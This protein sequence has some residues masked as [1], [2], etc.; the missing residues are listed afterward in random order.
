MIEALQNAPAF[1]GH[2]RY[3]VAFEKLD[4]K[5]QI[6][7]V[8]DV[9][10]RQ[11]LLRDKT[12]GRSTKKARAEVTYQAFKNLH[13]QGFSIKSVLNFSQRH[14]QALVNQWMEG[15]LAAA[16]L[17]T[18]FSILRWFTAAIGKN[19][20]LKEPS[21]Y[22][23]PAD[24]IKRVYVAVKDKSWSAIDLSF[25]E[26]IKQI[27]DKDPWVSM[28]LELMDAFGLRIQEATLLQP[29]AADGGSVLRVE[30]G[31]KGGRSRLVQI[32]SAKQRDV[33]NRAKSIAHLSETRN[34][35]PS[36]KILAQALARA[37][38]ICGLFG[39]TKNGMEITPH[40]LRA[41][42]AND[43]YEQ[44]SGMPST[45]RGTPEKFDPEKD[46]LARETVSRELGHSRLSITGAY[47]GARVRGRPKA[48]P[49]ND[50]DDTA[51][52]C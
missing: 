50:G 31:T 29:A 15:G 52:I 46:R 5:R 13:E 43:R 51:E 16:T 9:V 18:R 42:F 35:I 22:G 38:Y 24:S 41:G 48:V 44:L 23:I 11:H 34:L 47:T 1:L 19:G 14:V 30:M 32:Q 33:L 39:I 26:L 28:R 37:Y 20:M 25:D 6:Q 27:Y 3:Q 2:N 8:L 4:W 10:G 7:V 12:V 17:Q 21:E 49:K 36:G 40:G 45:V